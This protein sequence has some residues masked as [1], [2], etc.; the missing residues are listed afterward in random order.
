MLLSINKESRETIVGQLLAQIK[1]H[2]DNGTIKA[3]FR[4]PSSRELARS[5]GVNRT[6]IVHLYEELWAQG[7]IESTPGS[8]TYVRKRKPVIYPAAKDE[9]ENK[10]TGVIFLGR[11]D[12]NNEMAENFIKSLEKSEDGAIDLRHLI[13]D[14]RLLDKRQILNCMREV[15]SDEI[16]DPFVYIHP[17]GYPPLREELVNHMKLHNIHTSDK[18]ILITNGS[19]QSIQLILQ[20][21]SKPGD[22]IVL[23]A[24]TY[25]MLY[26]L[27]QFFRLEIIEVPLNQ[28]GMDLNVLKRTIGEK[29]V[30][31]IYTMP[32][33]QNPAGISMPQAEREDLLRF[34]GEKNCIIMED[35]MEEEMK[36]F[37]KAHLPLKS[38]DNNDLVLYLGT[39]SKVMA[40]GLRTGWIIGNHECI[41]QLTAVKTIFEISSGS[42]N[43]IFLQKFL[44]SGAY[45]LHLRK[46]MRVYRK[47]M[48]IAINSVKKYI[49]AEKVIWSE[50]TG[51]FL[52]WL[53]LLSK[54][55]DNIEEYF[56]RY[57]V[58]ISD[59][60][61]YFRNIQ[62]N[63]Y[64][65][66]CISKENESEIEEGIKRIGKAISELD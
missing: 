59:G 7:Y 43:Q 30:R 25:S 62:T 13:P 54:P 49:P 28:S 47:R 61:N 29:E 64:I 15:I 56:V 65:R 6:T 5:V 1:S 2:I 66:I 38:M 53:K 45:E 22:R 35:S 11:P 58:K 33:Y 51:G 10:K 46:L 18:N 21:F 34:C 20:V 44:R 42:L 8:Y 40:P 37:G 50:P 27:L 48:N 55:I 32:T 17:R 31:F 57:G 3:G 19:Q 12:V 26:P 41:R 63:N 24:P 9:S 14:T 52:I 4:M 39:F 36:Y 60:R 23:E 16:P